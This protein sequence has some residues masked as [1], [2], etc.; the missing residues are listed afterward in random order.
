MQI[1]NRELATS[2]WDGGLIRTYT[3]DPNTQVYAIDLVGSA[4]VLFLYTQTPETIQ[5]IAA[6]VD[7]LHEWLGTTP[8]FQTILLL[9]DAPREIS[10]TEWPSRISVNGGYTIPNSGRIVVYRKEEWERV[11]IHE[12][13]HALEWDWEMPTEPMPCWGFEDDEVVAPHLFEAWTELYAEWLWCGFFKVPWAAQRAHQ[14][15]Q[16]IQILARDRVAHRPWRENTNVFAYYVLK[17]ALAPH[18]SFLWVARNGTTP[19]ERQHILCDLTGPEMRRL[20]AEAAEEIPRAMSLRM[21][22]ASPLI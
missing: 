10:A 21:S 16:A 7:Q 11:L 22:V 12:T 2:T 6:N 4:G 15:A 3:E 18:I 20:K 9:I 8:K 17:A 19:T 5:D 14:D 1:V 13:I